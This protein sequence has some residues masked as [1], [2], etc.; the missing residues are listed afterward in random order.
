MFVPLQ[1]GVNRKQACFRFERLVRAG[2]RSFLARHAWS[3]GA[4]RARA[5][6]RSRVCVGLRSGAPWRWRALK[7]ACSSSAKWSVWRLM[8][9][10]RM[11]VISRIQR[12]SVPS[13]V[14]SRAKDPPPHRRWPGGAACP[15]GVAPSNPSAWRA[16]VH[17]SYRPEPISRVSGRLFWRSNSRGDSVTRT[18]GPHIYLQ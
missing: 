11:D 14:T 3:H 4:S 13:D 17:I 9:T 5:R 12:A 2:S 18:H 8:R 7:R 6:S 15:A 1:Y 10:A 16:T